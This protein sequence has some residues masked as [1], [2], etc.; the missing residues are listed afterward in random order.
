M[1][2]LAAMTRARGGRGRLEKFVFVDFKL[3]NNLIL[4][5]LS[6]QSSVF[7]AVMGSGRQQKGVR[8][9]LVVVVCVT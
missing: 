1:I 6:I 2:T 3:A 7:G 9:R 4:S 5:S 8:G